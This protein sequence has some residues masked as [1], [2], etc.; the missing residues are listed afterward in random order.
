M[1]NPWALLIV[2]TIALVTLIIANWDTIK[3]FLEKTWEAIKKTA[4]AVWEWIRGAIKKA[5]DFVVN[6]F[7]NWTLP[8]LIMKHWE[9]I[10]KGV[11]TVKDWITG[12]W[13]EIIGYFTGLPARVTTAVS[14]LWDGLKTA[15]KS[16]INWI[17][18]KWNNL[19][20]T[21]G[22]LSIPSWIPGIGGKEIKMSLNTPNIP[23][24]HGGGVF[25]APGGTRE[26]LALLKDRETVLPAGA[27]SGGDHYEII[28]H[29]GLGAD[30][31][32]I[33]R[34]I[35]EELQKFQRSNGP[36]PV[37]VRGA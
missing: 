22:P 6:L 32:Q 34:A 1:T 19:S 30:G 15:F 26:G 35:V 9:T 37:G 4:G 7:M 29:A 17:I 13:D 20:L 31:Q 10:K 28:V 12:K 33:G 23:R 5:V 18:D 25:R 21:I 3:A 24:L 8:G 11:A 27:R 36:I 14:G 16:A 2:A